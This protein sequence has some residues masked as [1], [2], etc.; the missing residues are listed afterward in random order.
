MTVGFTVDTAGGQSSW[1]AG[2]PW[3]GLK[4]K[5]PKPLVVATFRCPK[6]GYLESYASSA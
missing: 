3:E 1:I 4:T 5:K 6:C 2:L